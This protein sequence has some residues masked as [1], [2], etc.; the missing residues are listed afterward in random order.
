MFQLFLFALGT[1]LVNLFSSQAPQLLHTRS[2]SRAQQHGKHAHTQQM[3]VSIGVSSRS[4]AEVPV[5]SSVE[6][7][8]STAEKVFAVQQRGIEGSHRHS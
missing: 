5:L 1:Q 3:M 4:A 8:D 7:L 6:Q 2:T